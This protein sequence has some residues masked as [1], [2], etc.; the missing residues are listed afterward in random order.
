[1]QHTNF[2]NLI[3]PSHQPDAASFF[4]SSVGQ[5][6]KTALPTLKTKP[7]KGL[8]VGRHKEKTLHT[9]VHAGGFFNLD[10]DNASNSKPFRLHKCAEMDFVQTIPLLF[11]HLENSK[12]VFHNS[13]LVDQIFEAYSAVYAHLFLN[14]VRTFALIRST[15]R[16]QIFDGVIQST[17]D[18][19]LT[20]LRLFKM[21]NNKPKTKANSHSLI[22]WKAIGD[23]FPCEP[24]AC[25]DIENITLIHS[26]TVM[27]CLRLFQEQGKLKNCKKQNGKISFQ[28][29]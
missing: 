3:S 22:I 21:Q 11:D 19:F 18:D 25:G 24:F 10:G 5:L 20:A 6:A 15:C 26:T 14:W 28:V 27:A 29:I 16:K 2:S 1:M 9:R 7:T 13:N 4:P 23:H 17:D 8:T 12:V